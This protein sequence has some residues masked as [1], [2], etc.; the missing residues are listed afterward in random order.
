MRA[1]VCEGA[2]GAECLRWGD[3][4]APEA[5][6]GEVLIE[7]AAAGV[8]RADIL[9]RQGH[10]PPPPGASPLL[11]LECSGTVTGLGADVTRWKLG[12][13]VCALLAGG[14]YASHVAVPEGQ[15]LPV[16]GELDLIAAAALPETLCTVW[17]N[18]FMAAR[19]QPG[20]TLLV[21]GGA[22]GI[23]TTAINLA[24]Q[25]GAR[26]ICTAGSDEKCARAAELGAHVAV[27]YRDDDFVAR[28]REETDNRGADVILD[29]IGAR[30]LARNIE[31]LAPYGRLLIIGM[32]GGVRGEL[33]IGRLLAKNGTLHASSLRGKS[34]ARKASIVAS[35]RE[36]V[37]PTVLAGALSPV[38]D[39]FLPMERAAEAH[40]R[41]ER[42][43]HV[44]KMILVA[45]GDG[46]RSI[47]SARSSWPSSGSRSR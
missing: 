36:S 9:Q 43:D 41:I 11:G 34:P 39:S 20:E 3:A 12:D 35:V 1:V 38:I 47:C 15:L 25:R 46:R 17:S 44:G 32:Q 42:G 19:L 27:N 7:V 37:W 8:N 31:A 16:H 4:D 28:V 5:R 14:G 33:D 6:P 24:T 22:G 13:T 45:P 10:Y 26:V 23:G 30:Y 40:L 2:G 29:V 18:V 21:H